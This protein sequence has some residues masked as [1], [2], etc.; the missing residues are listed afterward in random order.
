MQTCWTRPRFLFLVSW[1]PCI[2][3]GFYLSLKPWY[4]L[5]LRHFFVTAFLSYIHIF[6]CTCNRPKSWRL[7]VF[8]TNH[9]SNSTDENLHRIRLNFKKLRTRILSE[10]CTP[11]FN[12]F[13]WT[14]T[15]R[16]D[17]KKTSAKETLCTLCYVGCSHYRTCKIT[18]Y[19]NILKWGTVF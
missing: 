8:V 11:Y 10:D 14:S 1:N 15:L 2:F 12:F 7:G 3:P 6:R 5:I 18:I 19:I 4:F 13:S 17:Q 9:N 16:Y